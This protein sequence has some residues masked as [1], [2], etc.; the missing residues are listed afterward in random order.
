MASSMGLI[1]LILIEIID[2]PS[3]LFLLVMVVIL[4]RYKKNNAS[5]KL[6]V[7]MVLTVGVVTSQMGAPTWSVA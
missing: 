2:I 4:A 7:L 6:A 3:A 1:T 5:G